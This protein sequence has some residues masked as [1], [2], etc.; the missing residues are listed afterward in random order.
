[1]LGQIAPTRLGVTTFPNMLPTPMKTPR[2]RDV[3]YEKLHSTARVL[4]PGRALT[5]EDRMPRKGRKGKRPVAFSLDSP[6]PGNG[7]SIFTDSKDRIPDVAEEAE[8]NP[9]VSQQISRPSRSA[10]SG[11]TKHGMSE[12]IDRAVENGE[13]MVYTL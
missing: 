6:S 4:F 10:T 11:H 2:K 5:P 13:G 12:E 7:I 1:M 9:F 8:E 3:R